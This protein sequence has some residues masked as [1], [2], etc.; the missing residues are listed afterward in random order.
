MRNLSYV[1]LTYASY[2]ERAMTS[3]WTLRTSLAFAGKTHV[4]P[5]LDNT[6]R[7]I[8]KREENNSAL[9]S[10]VRDQTL[11]GDKFTQTAST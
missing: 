1:S 2:T 4:S 10:P 8:E 11:V 5:P 6:R 3:N 7:S 9:V